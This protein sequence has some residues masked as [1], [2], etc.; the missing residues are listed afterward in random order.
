M[1]NTQNKSVMISITSVLFFVA[2]VS[3]STCIHVISLPYADEFVMFSDIAWSV[4]LLFLVL[5]ILVY[6]RK[7]FTL[8]RELRR[9]VLWLTICVIFG[10]L[11]TLFHRSDTR[12]LFSL[13]LWGPTLFYLYRYL[14]FVL[15]LAATHFYCRTETRIRRCTRILV[16]S[17]LGVEIIV[18]LQAVG[19]LPHFWPE[20]NFTTLPIYV[21]PLSAHHAHIGGYVLILV[22]LALQSRFL[23][24]PLLPRPVIDI[25]L[26]LSL[27]ILLYSQKR[28]AWAA[29]LVFLVFS[30]FA[31][32]KKAGVKRFIYGLVLVLGLICML[33]YL[34]FTQDLFRDHLV[35]A[36]DV[37]QME[38]VEGGNLEARVETP[39]I[40]LRE[41]NRS[42]INYLIGTGFASTRTYMVI[43][44][45]PFNKKLG[46]AHNQYVNIFIELGVPGL[47]AFLLLLYRFFLISRRGSPKSA[48]SRNFVTA[49]FFALVIYGAAGSLFF[50]SSLHGNLSLYVFV[51][52]ALAA[53]L[54]EYEEVLVR[55]RVLA[56]SRRPAVPV[57]QG[58]Q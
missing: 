11:V 20:L 41:F 32:I 9:P 3:V 53:R 37:E 18:L 46:G 5:T 10:S 29:M 8:P 58:L 54:I 27:P 43:Y 12:S 25:I 15:A 28:A 30:F 2:L 33:L 14:L 7:A 52:F 44:G 36:F 13:S 50:V 56:A 57:N 24:R 47:L 19:L 48:D 42:K 51:Y 34:V 49:T 31:I 6:R 21:G 39:L 16:L 22:G 38:M 40:Y 55:K 26:A 23:H 17:G 45:G 35:K 4:L 1:I